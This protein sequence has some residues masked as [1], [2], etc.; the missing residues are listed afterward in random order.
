MAQPTFTKLSLKIFAKL[1]QSLPSLQGF[2][3]DMAKVSLQA[4]SPGKSSDAPSSSKSSSQAN[5]QALWQGQPTKIGLGLVA[6]GLVMVGTNGAWHHEPDWF[7]LYAL[8]LVG[9]GVWAWAEVK[10]QQPAVTSEPP[11]NRASLRQKLQV[12]QQQIT[13][14][15]DPAQRHQLEIAIGQLNSQLGKNQF[16]I[17][18][19]GKGSTGKTAVLNALLGKSAAATGV[20]LGTTKTSTPYPY[21]VVEQIL[22]HLDSLAGGVTIPTKRQISLVDTPALEVPLSEVASKFVSGIKLPQ[23]FRQKALKNRLQNTVMPLAAN[24]DLLLFVIDSDLTATEY[25][26]LKYLAQ[27]GKRIILVFNKIDCYL[28]ADRQAIVAKLT[29][30]V[31]AWVQPEDIV[32][33]MAAPAPIRVRQYAT[34]DQT[35]ILKEWFEPMPADITALKNRIE[36]ILSEDWED[37]WCDNLDQQIRELQTQYQTLLH[38]QYRIVAEKVITRYQWLTAGA[39]FANPI[40]AIDLIGGTA[41]QTKML[42]ELGQIYGQP[43]ATSQAKAIGGILGQSLVQSGCVQIATNAITA[44]LTAFLKSNA[45]TYAIGGT[46]QGM[47]GA[48]V[49]RVA[50]LSFIAYLEQTTIADSTPTKTLEISP[51][52]TKALQNLCQ[53]T[54]QGLQGEGFFQ[55]FVANCWAYR[56]TMGLN[57]S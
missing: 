2:A 21:P 51:S 37:L 22:E 32:S 30:T 7:W 6:V 11:K 36:K 12:L 3:Q 55:E 5:Q 46:V 18:L 34:A 25:E 23:E 43:I 52:Q 26:S 38:Q 48:Y 8:A 16:Q 29:E 33:V 14:I 41:I 56:Q 20:T 17:V 40:P 10:Q 54:Y 44:C 13:Q 45:V 47:V 9:G 31:G 19:C 28:P 42:A 15:N 57:L 24:A 53:Q 27:Q 50:A 39:L 49:C 4:V 35:Q 1:S